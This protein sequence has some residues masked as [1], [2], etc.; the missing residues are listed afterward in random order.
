MSN[1]KKN[2][3]ASSILKGRILPIHDS[4]MSMARKENE[5]RGKN[6][7]WKQLSISCEP[8]LLNELRGYAA[9]EGGSMADFIRHALWELVKVYRTKYR[10]AVDR[11]IEWE[12]ERENQK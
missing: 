12:N 2:E 3:Y 7:K 9:F 8:E 1:K 10:E 4:P 6:V 5:L 11:A